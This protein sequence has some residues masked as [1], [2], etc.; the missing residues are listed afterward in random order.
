MLRIRIQLPK[1]EPAQNYSHLDLIH[2]ALVNAWV[3]AGADNSWII[4]HQAKPWNFAALGWHRGHK[5]F[6]HALVVSTSD[7][8]LARVLSRLDPGQIVKRRWN[9]EFINFSSATT[10]LESDPILPR[11]GQMACIFY[12]PLVLQDK[13]H[14]G[15][16]KRWHQELDTSESWLN[17]AVNRKLSF[18]AGREVNL[19]LYPDLLYL[20]ANPRHSVLVNLKTLKNGHKSFVIGMQAPLLLQGSEEDLRLAWYAG[21]GEK[22]RSGFGC[23]GLLEQGVG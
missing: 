7:A 1:G 16:V 4:G 3:A 22:N 20:R 2:D 6:T 9:K 11:Q 12:S 13:S 5:G 8:E 17:E 14:Q 21:I 23:L 10:H 19:E 15:K 18:L